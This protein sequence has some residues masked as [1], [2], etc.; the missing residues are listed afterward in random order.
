MLH[1][2]KTVCCLAVVSLS[3]VSDAGEAIAYGLSKTTEMHFDDER[4]AERHL[5]AVKKLASGL[6]RR[7]HRCPLSLCEM[8][9]HGSRQRQAG[10][11]MG[12]LE[13]KSG[14]RDSPWP[15]C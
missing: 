12:R 6:T 8:A 14:F 13:E 11:S 7:P 2:T 5:T 10:S 4:K 1:M 15:R 9:G 3:S